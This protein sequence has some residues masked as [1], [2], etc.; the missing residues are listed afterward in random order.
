MQLHDGVIHP[1]ITR[2]T[3]NAILFGVILINATENRG[4]IVSPLSSRALGEGIKTS[5]QLKSLLLDLR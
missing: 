1:K 5:T 3:E 4:A 2:F